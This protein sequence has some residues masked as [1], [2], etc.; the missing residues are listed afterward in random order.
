LVLIAG[1]LTGAA[2]VP[3]V[4]LADSTAQLIIEPAFAYLGSYSGHSEMDSDPL[5]GSMT[6]SVLS[7]VDWRLEVSALEPFTRI[8]DGLQLPAERW[9]LIYPDVSPDAYFEPHLA[10]SGGGSQDW[11]HHV[12]DWSL[13]QAILQDYLTPDDPPGRYRTRFLCVLVTEAG[14]QL[15]DPIEVTTE[16]TVDPWV[17]LDL[18]D[19]TASLDVQWSPETGAYG[20]SE[21]FGVAIRG[22]SSWSLSVSLLEP[23]LMMGYDA[24]YIDLAVDV[25]PPEA[26]ANWI[27]ELTDPELLGSA[28]LI[29]ASGYDP[30]PF[31]LN[32][33]VVFFRFILDSG[34]VVSSGSYEADV[35]FEIST[36]TY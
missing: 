14:Q 35:R 25:I 13:V 33:E 2:L 36:E 12:E 21:P 22:N 11:F 3:S 26:G 15:A 24:D 23:P 6:V 27:S 8:D 30:F 29:C 32:E 16:F 17:K 5:P 34:M 4:T 20:E 18:L 10:L 7:L 19:E 1:A 9:V 28:S 31:A